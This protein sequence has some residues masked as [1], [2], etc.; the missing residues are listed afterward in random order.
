MAIRQVMRWNVWI[1]VVL[2]RVAASA[3]V[4]IPVFSSAKLLD[5]IG[6][7]TDATGLGALVD[8]GSPSGGGPDGILD[9]VTALQ[10]QQLF[11]L[12]GRGDGTMSALGQSI[13]LNGI[14][15]ALATGDFDGDGSVDLAVGDSSNFLTVFRSLGGTFVPIGDGIDLRF[16]PRGI[17]AG[18]FDGD[19]HLDLVAVGENLQQSGLG[20]VLF[21]NGDGTFTRAAE[22]IETGIGTAG[23]AAGDF[24]VDGRLDLV[25]VSEV[26]N[27]AIQLRGDGRGGFASAQRWSTGGDSPS[28]VAAADVNGDGRA[29]LIV[30]NAASDSVAVGLTQTNGQWSAPTNYPTGAP[31]SSPRGLA[32]ADINGDGR[33]D[34]VVA[35][36]FSF[37]VGVMLGTGNGRFSPVRLFVADAEPVGVVAGD[38]NGDNRADVVALTRGGGQRPTAAVLM[39]LSGERLA[40]AENVPLANVPNQVTHGDVDG[41]GLLDLVLALAG[42]APGQGNLQVVTTTNDGKFEVWNPIAVSG[43][44]AGVIVADVDGDTRA[45]IVAVH[46]NTSRL[47]IYRAGN[48]TL[49]RMAEVALG[50]GTP[51][52]VVRSDFNRDGRSDIAV[53]LQDA[54]SGVVRV[55]AGR[56]GHGL[57]L[58]ST[59]SV[60]DI[61]LGLAVGDVNRDGRADLLT[62]NSGTLNVSVALGNGDGT[63]RPATS[64]GVAQAPRS[65]AIGDFDRDGFDDI[66]V[67]F[68]VG[69]TVQVLF[70]DGTGRFP[71]SISPLSFGSGGEVP[72]GLAARDVNGDGL[73]DIVASGEV[74]SI[75]RVFLRSGEPSARSFQ[76]AG[77]F[78]TNRRPV[79][80]VVGDLNGDGRYDASAAASS[81]APTTTVLTN[82]ASEGFRRGEANRDGRVTAADLVA[83]V[84]KLA[85][86][87]PLRVEDFAARG[88]FAVG[89]GA[90]ADGDGVLS[91]L[92]L[93]AALA[94][95]FR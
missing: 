91:S 36:N 64:V 32:V 90:D 3:Q 49:Q 58:S 83:V 21:G 87:T 38:L 75:V 16:L 43:N 77:I 79:S 48:E 72:S 17:V 47:E 76:S 81:P 93:G 88:A 19:R 26:A 46:G 86:F 71:S 70:G 33:L 51:H 28:A 68:P 61:P 25:V 14:P 27:E 11:V 7:T 2:L 8:V 23:V 62:A 94:W 65:L 6:S 41:D 74:G 31:A 13:D 1:V 12:F 5:L 63:F 9:L 45:E 55:F 40:G 35:N 56:S 18:D 57:E 59:I 22:T 10:S 66:A 29:D 60:G 89:P 95:A 50:T 92:D 85:E 73:P 82:I 20:R 78:P 37:D 84:R 4:A 30:L 44:A 34:I 42:N 15:T 53:A 67:G 80:L 54:G 39:S 69:G 52:A 24:N